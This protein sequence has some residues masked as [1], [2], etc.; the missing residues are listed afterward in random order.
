MG[1]LLSI[2]KKPKIKK[3]KKHHEREDKKVLNNK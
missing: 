2:C 3:R 1:D